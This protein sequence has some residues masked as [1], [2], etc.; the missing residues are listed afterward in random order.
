[1][2]YIGDELMAMWGAP[3]DQPDH[4]ERA[5][6]AALE[7]IES[8]ASV[9]TRWQGPL[10]EPTAVGIGINTGIARVGN[11]GSRRKF[12]YGPLGDTVNVASR[13][14]GASKY[15]KSNL[16]ITQATRDRLGPQ[17]QLV[18]LGQARVVNI[19]DPIELFELCSGAA[20]RR[21]ASAAPR[22]RKRC[23]R[24]RPESSARPRG[25]WAGSSMPIPTMGR[26]SHCSP[27]RSPMSSRSPR[28]SIRRFAWRENNRNIGAQSRLAANPWIDHPLI[29]T[30]GSPP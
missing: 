30:L 20:V 1:M 2:D 21:D 25:S 22:T 14:Q 27:A 17:F 13:V 16:L 11:T 8:I 4:A 15:F 3:E 19:A 9:N 29:P 26:P 12:K 18:R 6:Q 7:M 24:S 23:S 10:G 28:R 5:C